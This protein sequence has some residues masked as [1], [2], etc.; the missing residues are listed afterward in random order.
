MYW[1]TQGFSCMTKRTSCGY[2]ACLKPFLDKIWFSPSYEVTIFPSFLK[3]PIHFYFGVN[4]SNQEYG[5]QSIR[6]PFGSKN[7]ETW[8]KKASGSYNLSIKL[9]PNM[10]ENFPKDLSSLQA[11][12]STN[13]TFFF[14]SEN[15]VFRTSLAP[16]IKLWDKSRPMTSSKWDAN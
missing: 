8:T 12:P 15:L 13:F 1:N 16:W 9:P 11:S 10:K 7:W 2:W 14:K 4:S 6:T 5:E 3:P